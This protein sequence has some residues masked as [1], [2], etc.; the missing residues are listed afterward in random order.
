MKPYRALLLRF[1]NETEE[2]ITDLSHETLELSCD[3][4]DGVSV[5]LAGNSNDLT[6][7]L[8]FL[9]REIALTL[10]RAHETVQ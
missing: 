5:M 7:A 1:R 4:D 3:F 8:K 2:R 9:Q 6:A 10:R